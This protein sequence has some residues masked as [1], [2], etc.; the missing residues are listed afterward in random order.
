M[1]YDISQPLTPEIR[2]WPGDV[3]LSRD[4]RHFDMGGTPVTST[5]LRATV[6]LGTH[7]DA[8][9]HYVPGDLS[10]DACDLDAYIGRCQVFRIEVPRGG[11]VTPAML[12]TR[13]TTPPSGGGQ[14]SSFAP[15][16]PASAITAPRVLIATNTYPDPTN[17]NEDFA[18]LSVELIDHL[19]AAGVRLV[20]VDTP[21]VDRFADE[22]LPVHR[23][24][25]E[26]GMLILEGLRLTDVPPGDYDLIALPLR[27][28]GSDGSPVR[29]VLRSLE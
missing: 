27:L 13:L 28:T 19:H 8:P 23:R 11:A 17:F 22:H 18:G 15:A 6:H 5:S 25:G 21:S 3:P 20:G 4:V 12:T 9:C 1:I 26:T 2:V 24:I 10:I 7:A 14:S 16:V 29:A